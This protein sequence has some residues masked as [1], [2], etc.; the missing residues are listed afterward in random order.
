MVSVRGC[1]LLTAASPASIVHVDMADLEQ[2][3]TVYDM[4]R[5]DRYTSLSK[6][7]G[8]SPPDQF[9]RG[10]HGS[11]RAR[12]CNHVRGGFS[13]SPGL[14]SVKMETAVGFCRRS[15]LRACTVSKCYVLSLAM[16]R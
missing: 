8:P 16:C 7:V 11:H 1:K 15:V 3:I 4:D 14:S 10:T 9:L 13:A 12:D 2:T 6:T 5:I